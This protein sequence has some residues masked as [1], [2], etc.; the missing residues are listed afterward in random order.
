MEHISPKNGPVFAVFCLRLC[1]ARA[2][3][4]LGTRIHGQQEGQMKAI[5]YTFTSNALPLRTFWE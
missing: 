5:W 2:E 4:H 3:R 1:N